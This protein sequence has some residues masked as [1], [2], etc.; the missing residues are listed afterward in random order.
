MLTSLL[1]L[2]ISLSYTTPSYN[3]LVD[4][5]KETAYSSIKIPIQDAPQNSDEPYIIKV[6]AGYITAPSTNI[7]QDIGF[8]FLESQLLKEEGIH[9]D[10]VGLG[11]PWHPTTTFKDGRYGEPDTIGQALFIKSWMDD[12]IQKHPWHDMGA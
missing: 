3:A 4:T 1:I 6:A 5:S 2:L 10:R 9:S 11:R 7:N 12:H 8:V